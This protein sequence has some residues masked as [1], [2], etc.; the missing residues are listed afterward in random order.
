MTNDTVIFRMKPFGGKKSL[1]VQYSI[2]YKYII[3]YW[4]NIHHFL[5]ILARKNLLSFVTIVMIRCAFPWIVLTL[6]ER[7]FN[8]FLLITVYCTEF[9]YFFT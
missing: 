2:I 8:D 6:L 7:L 9:L 4:N 3:E 5:Q 1:L